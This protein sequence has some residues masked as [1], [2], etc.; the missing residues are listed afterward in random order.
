MKV[1]GMKCHAP[2]NT[3]VVKSMIMFVGEI[4]FG[5]LPIDKASG[6][7]FV[8][9][10][11]FVVSIILMNLLN[12][13]AVDDIGK[14]RKDAEWLALSSKIN[15]LYLMEKSEIYSGTFSFFFEILWGIPRRCTSF[16]ST[17]NVLLFESQMKFSKVVEYLDEKAIGLSY[18]K[19]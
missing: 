19:E 12:G 8:L 13:L 5:D 16:S 18:C 10:F 1:Q 6:Y 15:N 17:K 7:L 2:T 9:T 14:I 4:E 11:I 3:A